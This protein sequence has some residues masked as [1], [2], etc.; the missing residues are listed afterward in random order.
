M[1][2]DEIKMELK[3]IIAEAV[4][5]ENFEIKDTLTQ[6]EVEGWSSLAQAMIIKD[7]ETMFG[8]KFKLIDLAA[9]KNINDLLDIIE[10]KRTL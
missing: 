3:N 2:R 1:N 9:W 6:E 10:L 8:F 5:H 4:G 7:I